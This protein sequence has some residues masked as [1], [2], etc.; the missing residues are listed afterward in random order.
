[1]LKKKKDYDIVEFT[2][3]DYEEKKDVKVKF[4]VYL[5]ELITLNG[6]KFI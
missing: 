2:G 3:Y 6:K 5:N 1:M 4:A